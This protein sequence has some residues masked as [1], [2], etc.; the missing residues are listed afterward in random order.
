MIGHTNRA[1]EAGEW[2]REEMIDLPRAP[3]LEDLSLA[4][5]VPAPLPAIENCTFEG[6]R[7]SDGSAGTKNILGIT[8]TVQ[9]VAPTVDFAA[10]RIKS[11]VLP[12]FPNVDDV[13]PI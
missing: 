13:V 1:I 3:R 11:E 5:A 6:Y 8:T 12:H 2:V 10:R 9:C 7:N 4:T